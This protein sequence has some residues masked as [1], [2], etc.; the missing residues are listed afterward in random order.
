MLIYFAP[1]E[2]VT[3]FTYRR[4][5]SAHF[6]GIHKY[7]IP[8]VSPTQN[9]C[10]TPRDIAAIS[11][12]HNA[13][14]PVVPQVLTRHAD[15]FFWAAQALCDMGYGE[16]NLN[17][18]CPAG[19]VTA[20]GKGAGMLTDAD[21]LRRFLDAV[22]AKAPLPVSIKTRLGF[23]D[24]SEW[25]ALLDVYSQYPVSELIVHA[26]TRA[27]FYAGAPHQEAFAESF[28]RCKFPLVY[29]G[30]LFTAGD[31]RA[32]ID[33]CPRTHAL[34]IGRGL[35]AN[36]ALARSFAGGEALTRPALRG[37]HDALF[38]AYLA[39]YPPHVVLGKMREVMKHAVFCFESPEKPL[40]AI[41]KACHLR[42]YEEA[43]AQ[44]F[45]AHA[46]TSEPCFLP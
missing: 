5:H 4:T 24:V 35:I 46:F 38:A 36:P 20:K 10:W 15:H 23:A 27:A 16:I 22:Y 34:M 28:A 25:A 30:D 9:L 2:G 26:R 43:V 29:N 21:A 7:F 44:L 40:K 11:P 18:G 37:F 39:Q 32:L 13:G 12:A 3:D 8:F 42:A 41:R 19:T 14:L 17:L 45:D 1:L 6:G 31:C 33:A